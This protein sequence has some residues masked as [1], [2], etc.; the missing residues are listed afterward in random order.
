M[1]GILQGSLIGLLR[2]GVLGVQSEFTLDF[3]QDPRASHKPPPQVICIVVI[4]P[5]IYPKP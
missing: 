4:Y 3:F 2:G 5:K 1:L